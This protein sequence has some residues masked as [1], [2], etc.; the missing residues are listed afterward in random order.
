MDKVNI[1]IDGPA[2]AGKSTVARQL[3]GRLSYLY[4][5]TGAMYRALTWKALQE[6]LP[7]HD[8]EQLTQLLERIKLEL[9]G[10]EEA[11]RVYVN[12]AEVTE[13]VRTPEVTAAVSEV[14]AHEAVRRMMAEK[15]RMLAANRRAVLDGRDIGSH[16]LPDA[17][18]KVFL[19]ASVDE[20]AKRR[21]EE[22]VEKGISSD[23]EEIKQAIS[24]RDEQDANRTIAPLVKARDAYEIDTTNQ[25]VEDVVAEIES[26]LRQLGET[27]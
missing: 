3:A 6:D 13:G 14:S 5:D 2:G 25:Q 4:V 24:R 1:A 19:T 27:P 11:P 18:L 23:F 9:G 26:L 8:E 12:D 16:V 17:E 22:N 21:H 10:N 7:L 15:Q 20:R